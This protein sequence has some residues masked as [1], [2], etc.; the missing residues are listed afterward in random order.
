MKIMWIFRIFL[1][2][3]AVFVFIE[4]DDI[5]VSLCEDKMLLIEAEYVEGEVLVGFATG[6]TEE[7]VR[8]LA[9]THGL[10]LDYK[11]EWNPAFENAAKFKVPVGQ[12]KKIV[13]VMKRQEVIEFADINKK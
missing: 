8:T 9:E 13:C 1:V 3:A 7:Q 2:L 4:R 5:S 6:T 12:E 10:E 11:G